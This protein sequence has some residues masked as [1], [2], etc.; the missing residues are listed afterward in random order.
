MVALVADDVVVGVGG[1]DVVVVARP[2]L[3]PL[4][5]SRLTSFDVIPFCL[6]PPRILAPPSPA[7]L[8][9]LEEMTASL[10][11]G[12]YHRSPLLFLKR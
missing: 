6:L 4:I 11:S 5:L 9:P 7:G 1:T 3:P 8:N 2:V 10:S 12:I